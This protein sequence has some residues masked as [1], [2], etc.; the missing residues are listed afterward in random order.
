MLF[1]LQAAFSSPAEK[2]MPDA[3]GEIALTLEPFVGTAANPY[4]AMEDIAQSV[5]YWRKFIPRDGMRLSEAAAL[6]KSRM[7]YK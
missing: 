6:Q 2:G 4:D 7:E 1:S 3:V 5:A